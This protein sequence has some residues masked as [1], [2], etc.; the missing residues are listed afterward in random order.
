M[1]KLAIFGLVTLYFDGK[2]V[3]ILG[4]ICLQMLE[5][6]NYIITANCFLLYHKNYKWFPVAVL[7]MEA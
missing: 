2:S 5:D 1:T 4:S 6:I 3:W 7:K